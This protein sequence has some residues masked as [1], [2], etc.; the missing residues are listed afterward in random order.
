MPLLLLAFSDLSKS[1]YL[2]DKVAK[3]VLGSIVSTF[4]SKS[5]SEFSARVHI[6]SFKLEIVLVVFD[7]SSSKTPPYSGEL[8]FS[9]SILSWLIHYN[10]VAIQPFILSRS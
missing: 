7:T 6:S 9:L 10:A 2:K 5:S 8:I 3:A 1:E 4:R